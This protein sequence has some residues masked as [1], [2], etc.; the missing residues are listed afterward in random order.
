M[1]AQSY[2]F[3]KGLARIRQHVKEH[4]IGTITAFRYGRDCG[5]GEKYTKAENKK[6]NSSLK[7]KLLSLGYSVTAAVGEYIE[8]YGSE[9][10]R[11][12][13]EEIFIVSDIKNKGTLLKDLRRLGEEFDQDSILYIERG[14]NTGKL[15]GTSTCENAYPPKG[16][17]VKLKNAIFGKSGMFNTRVNGRP[18]TLREEFSEEAVPPTGF[19]GAYGAHLRATKDWSELVDEDEI[20]SHSDE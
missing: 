20:D 4:D 3:E 18:F 10:A 5:R 17:S 8:N 6:R 11:S 2:L 9:D 12:V 15:V 1:K 7:S 14:N 16:K 13:K 19:F